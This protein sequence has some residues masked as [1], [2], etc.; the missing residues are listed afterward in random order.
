MDL[1]SPAIE[2]PTQDEWEL[3]HELIRASNSTTPDKNAACK[4]NTIYGKTNGQ[5][6]HVSKI[7]NL[8][9]EL[10]GRSRDSMNAGT[11]RSNGLKLHIHERLLR[12]LLFL[13]LDLSSVGRDVLCLSLRGP[14][15]HRNMTGRLMSGGGRDLVRRLPSSGAGAVVNGED[16]VEEVPL[17]GLALRGGGEGGAGGRGQSGG[18]PLGTAGSPPRNFS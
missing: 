3:R 5:A 16:M 18:F 2:P 8:A 9:R 10:T 13:R 4:G 7:P 15:G 17:L 1:Q 6:E 12:H 11:S 14:R